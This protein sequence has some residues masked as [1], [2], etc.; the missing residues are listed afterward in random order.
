MND[1]LKPLIEGKTSWGRWLTISAVL[2]LL[3]TL[4][5]ITAE[6]IFLAFALVFWIALLIRRERTLAFPRFF[7]PLL[8]YTALS[9]VATLASKSVPTSLGDD[10]GM[11][12]YLI[13]PIAMAAFTRRDEF[14]PAYAALLASA[15]VSAL[16]AIGYFAVA[17]QGQLD[18]AHRVRAFMSHY[19]T[20]GGVMLLFCCVALAFALFKRGRARLPWVAGLA[21][22]AA[23]LLLTLMRS[24]WI[25]IG[26]ALCVLLA[27]R[28]PKLIL[29]VPV[30]AALVYLAGPA[31]VKARFRS[32]FSLQG[33]SNAERV[34]YLKA[35]LKIVRDYPL[36]GTGPKT[37]SIVFQDP[38]YGLSDLARRNVHL[39]SNI[40]Q[41]AAER[42][43][44]ALLAW[45]AF[46]VQALVSLARL[47]RKARDPAVFAAAAGALAA[48]A[49]FF[50]AGL[51]EYNFGDAEVVTLL[52]FVITLPFA[53][54]RA[55]RHCE[56]DRSCGTTKQSRSA[57]AVASP[58]PG[59]R[60]DI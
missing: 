55:N 50:V 35:G 33:Y 32:I 25:G 43:L 18:T 60:N 9:L 21:L 37:V 57:H 45:L 11:L 38:K 14:E 19:M 10:K 27:L 22:G 51:M 53:M 13:V 49:A 41:I 3:F 47:V 40:M 36:F 58:P 23:A 8:A 6:Q 31:S 16:Y 1:F 24:G 12:L 52:M 5:S 46:V 48:L 59:A 4:V 34:E 7:W 20:Q 2:T 26:L 56:E 44:F 15:A 54:E 28:R 29:L 30:L 17:F 42:G 39:H